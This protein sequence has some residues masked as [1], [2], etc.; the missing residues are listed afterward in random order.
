MASRGQAR[1]EAP[2]CGRVKMRPTATGTVEVRCTKD[3]GHVERGDPKH[4]GKTGLFPLV[5]TD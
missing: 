4:Y 1:Q 5:W 3:V 2:K